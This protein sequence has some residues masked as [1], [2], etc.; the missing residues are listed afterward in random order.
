MSAEAKRCRNVIRGVIVDEQVK[1]LPQALL[2]KGGFGRIVNIKGVAKLCFASLFERK[3]ATANDSRFLCHTLTDYRTIVEDFYKVVEFVEVSS[4]LVVYLFNSSSQ[5]AIEG[6]DALYLIEAV[7]GN[8]LLC[9][10]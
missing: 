4:I 3:K 7:L 1:H 2:I 5:S 8:G 9:T 6:D 10:E